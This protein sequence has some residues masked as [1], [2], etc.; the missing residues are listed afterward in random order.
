MKQ[1]TTSETPSSI[2]WQRFP[3]EIRIAI[4][5]VLLQTE[6][7]LASFATVSR[8]WQTIIEQHSF[9]RIK[10]TLGSRLA[11][12]GSMMHR[13]RALV[14]YVWFCVELQ[15]YDC[16]ECE[17]L[18]KDK[19]GL[20]LDDNVR[21]VNGLEALFSTLSTWEP[22]PCREM[23]QLDISVHSPSDS[24]HWYKYLTFE[25][26]LPA[27]DCA[28]PLLKQQSI[29]LRPEYDDHN[30]GWRAGRQ[31]SLPSMAALEKTFDE[32]MDLGPF[33]NEA[34]DMEW[35]GRLPLIPAVTNVLLRQQTRRRWKP[36]ALAQLLSRFP[37][38]QEIHYEP[39]REWTDCLQS[40]TDQS[41]QELFKSLAS[42]Q[43]QLQK[44]VL[45]ENSALEYTR[46]QLFCSPFR[47]ASPDVSYALCS[48]SLKLE[49]LSASFIVEASQFFDCACK[50]TS[51]LWANLTSVAL[52]T[53][54]LM[55]GASLTRIEDML[56]Q[57]AATA[58]RMPKLENMEIWNGQKGSAML[59]RY[60]H[61]RPLSQFGTQRSAVIIWKGTW[62]RAMVS[63]L[64]PRSDAAEIR[65]H[66]DAICCLN[67]SSPV[68][69]P[70]SL[71]QIRME[72]IIREGGHD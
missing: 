12:F 16:S 49:Q 62:T 55:P 31:V 2:S 37:R 69:R 53:R 29:L 39:W 63:C 54:L 33:E 25:P 67:L 30:H 66:G 9:S 14:R 45:F 4:L 18:D 61:R 1:I 19:W 26:D 60:Q 20:S 7:S 57:A 10:L 70:I 52:T 48:T 42:S 59:F 32:I 65:S 21:I 5:E 13:N 71:R 27:E 58:M 41:S 8:E 36:Q 3:A 11:N 17:S 34:Q 68:I 15:A 24:E 38:L 23:L 22:R 35:W 64:R 72:Q 50:N 43:P 56:R 6:G 28:L 44:L 51:W 46:N 47:T 40:F